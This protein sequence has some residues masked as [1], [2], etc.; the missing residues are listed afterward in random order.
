VWAVEHPTAFFVRDRVQACAQACTPISAMNYL[1][2]PT[3]LR[4]ALP[5]VLVLILL[6]TLLRARATDTTLSIAAAADLQ[7]AF[8]ELVP[9]FERE[10][11]A[12]VTSVFGSTGLLSRQAE[13]GAPFD[14]LFAA[15]EKYVADL[16]K[17]GAVLPKTRALYA[18]GRIVVWTRKANSR[19]TSLQNLVKPSYRRIAI[20]NPE[21]APYGAAAREALQKAGL[22][23]ALEKRMVYGENVQQTLQYAQTGNTDAAIVALSLVVRSEGNYLVVPDNLHNPIRQ[24]AGILKQCKN[25]DIARRFIQFVLSPKGQAVM[26][27]YGFTLPHGPR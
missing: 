11:G 18:V 16:E 8:K 23:S 19:P 22:W 17:K 9:Q 4:A 27:R 15:N 25:P 1:S 13:Q 12:K 21:H 2:R 5:L 7:K 26:R 24:A 14:I 6:S 20:A 3:L 10:S